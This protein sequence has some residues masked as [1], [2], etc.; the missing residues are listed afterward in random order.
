ML[1]HCSESWNN[2]FDIT[3]HWH[4]IVFSGTRCCNKQ[5]THLQ[6]VCLMWEAKQ[7]PATWMSCYYHRQ[8][9]LPQKTHSRWHT[10]LKALRIVWVMWP[11][12]QSTQHI[13]KNNRSRLHFNTPETK[14]FGLTDPKKKIA[15]SYCESVEWLWTS[16]ELNSETHT[17]QQ[18]LFRTNF[19]YGESSSFWVMKTRYEIKHEHHTYICVKERRKE[20][21]RYKIVQHFQSLN[22]STPEAPWM[23]WIKSNSTK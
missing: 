17:L 2:L 15:P 16:N 20:R 9:L 4:D 5:K 23:M 12:G 18:S 13:E 3:S 1:G 11:W 21:K 22:K 6:Q 14:S 19:L 10:H 8:R 7:P